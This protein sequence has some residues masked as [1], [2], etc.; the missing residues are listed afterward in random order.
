M[1]NLTL[2][3]NEILINLIRE[4]FEEK[5]YAQVSG[6]NKFGYLGGNQNHFIVSRENGSDTKIPI[7]KI[8]SAIEAVRKENAVYNQGP[9]ALRKYGITHINSPIWAI[10]HLLTINEII[11]D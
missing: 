8:I 3:R 5:G 6:N 1:S 10:L 2:S 7:D 11:A 9:S 4:R